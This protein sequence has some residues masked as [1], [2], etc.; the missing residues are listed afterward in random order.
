MDID[1]NNPICK[2]CGEEHFLNPEGLCLLCSIRRYKKPKYKPDT[3]NKPELEDEEILNR[4]N[5]EE[6]P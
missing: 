4:E 1:N 6:L 3:D 5:R 2:N